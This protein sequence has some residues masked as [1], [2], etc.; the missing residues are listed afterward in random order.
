MKQSLTKLAYKFDM[1]YQMK[2]TLI[3]LLIAL[4]QLN[5][6]SQNDSTYFDLGINAVRLLTLTGNHN[7]SA[8]KWINPYLIHAEGHLSILSIRLGFGIQ[9][10]SSTEDPSP[11]NGNSTFVDDTLKRDFRIGVG[12]SARLSP[13]WTM[14]YGIDGYFSKSLTHKESQILDINSVIV[15]DI[16]ETITEEKGICPFLFFQYHI[17]PRISIG[18]ELLMRFGSY[19]TESKQTNSGFPDQDAFKTINGN[20][21]TMLPGTALFLTARF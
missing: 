19:T 16:N 18:T 21:I 2:K 4:L 20:R 12:L 14:K 13:K 10:H 5:A 15:T 11:V 3:T 6:K 17:A 1:L 9:K 8:E 7:G